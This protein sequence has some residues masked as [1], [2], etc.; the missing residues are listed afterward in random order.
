[1]QERKKATWNT[2]GKSKREKPKLLGQNAGSRLRRSW[3]DPFRWGPA[4][5]IHPR[6]RW[7]TTSTAGQVSRQHR[8]HY[9]FFRATG[10]LLRLT[11]TEQ[12]QEHRE[13]LQ[14]KLNELMDI[15][16]ER[17]LTLGTPN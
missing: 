1:M 6:P 8:L 11:E 15:D 16:W 10:G 12:Y 13:E 5:F 14:A 17:K 4:F 9:H 7:T 2:P 3:R